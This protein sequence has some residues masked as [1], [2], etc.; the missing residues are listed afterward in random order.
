MSKS[1]RSFLGCF[2]SIFLI[3]TVCAVAR[4][5]V[6]PV[7]RFRSVDMTGG[8]PAGWVW[9]KKAGSPTMKIG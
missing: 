4:A 9:D 5:A 1:T 3:V 8:A 6:I 2:L 7:T